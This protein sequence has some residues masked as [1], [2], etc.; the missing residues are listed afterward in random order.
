MRDAYDRL[1][2]VISPDREEPDREEPDREEK[3]MV[4]KLS[5]AEVTARLP[6][7]DNW[8]LMDGKLLKTFTFDSFVQAFGFMSSVALLAEAMR[9]HPDWSNVYNR[10]TIGLNT[11]DMGG[12]TERDF[13]L[14]KQIDEITP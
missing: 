6:E 9:H 8:Q 4:E 7:L 1:G 12:I 13:A 14:A 5:D 10:V 2:R 3:D 11:H